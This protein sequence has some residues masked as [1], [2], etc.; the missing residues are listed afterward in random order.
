[1]H[2]M[3]PHGFQTPPSSSGGHSARSSE[4]VR[5][6][7]EVFVIPA[8]FLL[9]L[10]RWKAGPGRFLVAHSAGQ[11]FVILFGVLD[12]GFGRDDFHGSN[13]SDGGRTW[14]SSDSVAAARFSAGADCARCI[15]TFFIPS[16]R[17]PD[18][19]KNSKAPDVRGRVA[20]RK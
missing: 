10:G 11:V 15:E 9:A 1:M 4:P 19:A 14:A 17:L 13:S 6:H 12:F 20:K 7:E 8:Q 18:M 16:T 3:P 5:G 2:F